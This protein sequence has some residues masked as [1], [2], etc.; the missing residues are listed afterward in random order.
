MSNT[1]PEKLDVIYPDE[2]DPFTE[3]LLEDIDKIP[4]PYDSQFPNEAPNPPTA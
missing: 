1:A 2:L 4:Y 3:A